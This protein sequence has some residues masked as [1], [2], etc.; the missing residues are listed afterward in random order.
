MA[1]AWKSVRESTDEQAALACAHEA[2]Q[3]GA[4]AAKPSVRPSL[5]RKRAEPK[6]PQADLKQ[7]PRSSN[8]GPR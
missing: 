7:L 8:R 6:P 1:A 3:A 4:A 5:A 2:A